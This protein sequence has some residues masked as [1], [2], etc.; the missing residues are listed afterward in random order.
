MKLR[1]SFGTAWLS[2]QEIARLAPGSVIELNSRAEADVEVYAGGRYAARG[3]PMVV[4]G[5]LAVRVRKAFSNRVSA[6]G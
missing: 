5:S 6:S 4:D 2:P 3:R 1:I